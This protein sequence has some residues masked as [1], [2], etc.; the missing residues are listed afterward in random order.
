MCKEVINHQMNYTKIIIRLIVII[1]LLLWAVA[2]V[3]G[4]DKTIDPYYDYLSPIFTED[5]IDNILSVNDVRDKNHF[6]SRFGAICSHEQ[7]NK[8]FVDGQSK[9]L[10]GRLDKKMIYKDF[11]TQLQ[12]WVKTYNKYRYKNNTPSDWIKKSK[13]CVSDSHGWWAWCPNR[14]DNVPIIR[15]R[16]K[17]LSTNEDKDHTIP[18]ELPKATKTCRR[19]W[20]IWPNEYIQIDN[21]RWQF[22]QWIK[23]LWIDDKVFICKDI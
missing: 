23:N 10:C 14:V 15:A 7:G 20:T 8:T 2:I 6:I 4:E 22:K 11:Q 13:Y 3:K 9:Y 16:A 21:K 18:V 1:L 12:E 17:F 19:V 5:Q